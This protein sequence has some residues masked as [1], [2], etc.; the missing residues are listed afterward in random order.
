MKHL[1]EIWQYKK[2]YAN[3]ESAEKSATYLAKAEVIENNNT[4]RYSRQLTHFW[5]GWLG[6]IAYLKSPVCLIARYCAACGRY[7]AFACVKMQIFM[8]KDESIHLIWS[9]STPQT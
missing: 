1:N 7:G 4:L 8:N 5:S 6:I 3:R 2:I 9:D